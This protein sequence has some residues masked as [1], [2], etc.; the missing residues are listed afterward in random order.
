MYYAYVL[1]NQKGILYKGQT[2]DLQK[3]V[4]QHNNI[5]DSLS[6]YTKKRGPWVLIYHESFATRKEAKVREAYFKT[7]KGRTFLAEKLKGP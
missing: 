1:R 5:D 4:A 2:K 3:R 6:S 7:G